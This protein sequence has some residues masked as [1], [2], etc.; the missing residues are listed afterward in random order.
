MKKMKGSTLR[1]VST[2]AVFV[3]VGVGL[4]TH[5]GG[6]T[7][8]AFGAKSIAAICPL[9]ALETLLASKLLVPQ[10]VISLVVLLLLGVVL[11][12]VFCGWICPVP[13]VRRIFPSRFRKTD[14]PDG[15]MTGGAAGPGTPPVITAEAGEVV[16]T[17]GFHL[18]RPK[19]VTLDTR[20]FVLGG[21]LI[22]TAV[23]GFPVFCLVCPIGLTFATAIALWRLFG[24]NEPTVL[25]LVFPAILVLE[26]VIFRKWCAR[27]CPLGALFSL[28]ASLN[29]R[30]R[31][32]VDESRC[33]RTAKSTDCR[34]CKT[35]CFE[36]IDLHRAKDSRPMS[37][38]TKCRDCAD[39]C[40]V[41]AISFPFAVKKKAASVE[42]GESAPG[43]LGPL[44][45]H[46][47]T[48]TPES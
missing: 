5:F 20:H 37:E 48:S 28:A 10:A 38:C 42:A 16:E 32:V 41:S 6:G 11:G 47:G 19:K 43:K 34:L 7:I 44:A 22:S 39:A 30:L 1:L 8:S 23:F 2:L 9:G 40:P 18:P 13:L 29:T 17:S 14:E 33:L 3:I 27:I 12:R 4:A 36:E 31:P 25:L 21:A 26:L 24:Y 15:G 46:S 35:A 45:G